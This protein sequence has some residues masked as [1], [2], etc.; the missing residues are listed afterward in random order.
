MSD[1]LENMDEEQLASLLVLM[2]AKG[3]N[4]Y[5]HLSLRLCRFLSEFQPHLSSRHL[6]SKEEYVRS[7]HMY[8]PARK[9]PQLPR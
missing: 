2:K 8:D 6:L 7:R 5:R 1:I 4:G 9:P 3:R